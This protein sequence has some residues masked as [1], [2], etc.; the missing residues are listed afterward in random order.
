MIKPLPS[1]KEK[2]ATVLMH[3]CKK[4]QGTFLNFLEDLTT[5]KKSWMAYKDVVDFWNINYFFC[6]LMLLH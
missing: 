4:I 5:T 6:N 1:G 2:L 3:I